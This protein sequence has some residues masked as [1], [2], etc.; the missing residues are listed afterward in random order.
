M[1]QQLR[2]TTEDLRF[3]D[4]IMK[5]VQAP[6]ETGEGGENWIREQFGGYFVAM[7]RTIYETNSTKCSEA[8]CFNRLFFD[9]WKKTN[10]FQEWLARKITCSAKTPNQTINFDQMRPA[11]PFSTGAITVADMRLK[12]A[13]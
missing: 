11:H 1:R 6:K 4:Y 12:I 13:Q 2:L 5:N 10:N 9:A 3:V 7:L 8:E